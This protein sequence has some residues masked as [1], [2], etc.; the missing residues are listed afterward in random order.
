ML[1]AETR[2]NF[3]ERI[4]K[5]RVAIRHDHLRDAARILESLAAELRAHGQVEGE[6]ERR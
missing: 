1:P 6:D 5:V 3:D 4:H 2:F